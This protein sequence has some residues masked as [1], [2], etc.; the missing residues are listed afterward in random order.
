MLARIA[1]IIVALAV[2]GGAHAQD[3]KRIDKAAD[4]PR[5]SYKVGGKLDAIV[6]DDAKFRV[7]AQELRRDTE[8]VLAQYDI[9]DKAMLRQLLGTIARLDYL[10]GRYDE[11]LKG[12]AS[13]RELE[14]KPADKL[15]SGLSM[16]SMIAAERKVGNRTSDAYRAEVRRMVAAELDGMPYDVVQ[17]E[18]KEAKAGNEI[19]SEALAL[20]YLREAIQ[21]TVDKAGALSSDLAPMLVNARYRIVAV[22]PVKDTF[23][24]AYSAYL[25]AHK[26]EKPDIWV[27]RDVTLAPGKSQAPVRIAIWDSGVDTKLF[28]EQLVKGADG[29]PAVIA[30]DKY[31]NAASG[32][33][34]PIPAALQSKVPQMKARLKGFSDLQSNIDSPEASEVKKF[35]STLKPDEY[36]S[37]IEE[38]NL[39]G[40]WM[41]GTHVAGIAVAGNPY[42]RLAV[43]R[44]EF[45]NTLRPDPCPSKELVE[46]DARNMQS[47]VDFMKK[48]DVRV[49]NMSWGGSVKGFEEDLELCGIGQTPDERK[50]IA[51]EYF[52]TQKNALTKAMASAPEILFVAAAG[53]ANQDSSFAEAIPAGIS[54]PNLLTVGAVDKAGDEASF[55]SYGPTVVVHANGYQVESVIPGGDKLAESGTSMASPQVANLAG[56]VLAVNP[57][58]KPA[59]VIAVI[60]DTADKTADG[61]RTLVNPKKAVETALK[62]AA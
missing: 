3:K 49:V 1:T 32:D 23:V 54:L 36:K 52:D 31:A 38:I 29:K 8:S 60:R 58:L 34:Q 26:V 2:A 55:T 18:I 40:N 7:F 6:R 47:Y 37:A 61:R 62:K 30:F 22:L 13:I 42:A 39:A 25:D 4:L 43:A 28:P 12:A 20:G 56:K 50:A 17:N 59:E 9:A 5:F 21:P 15:V 48:N 24:T 35:L 16:R 19:A 11:A 51:R 57:A 10:E 46:R 53:N 14:D 41:H 45:G 27:A 33:L 44:I